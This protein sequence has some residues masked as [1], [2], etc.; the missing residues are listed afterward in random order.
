MNTDNN[1]KV[2]KKFVKY[3]EGAAL[4]GMGYS[5]FVKLAKEA[6]AVYK[7]NRLALVKLEVLDRYLELYHMI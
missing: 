1:D 4:Y 5:S 7:I 6:D 2:V 3:K